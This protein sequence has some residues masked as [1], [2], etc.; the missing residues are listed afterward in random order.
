MNP[1][2]DRLVQGSEKIINHYRWLLKRA[3][4]DRERAIYERRI[5]Q[6]ERLLQQLFQCSPGAIQ[7]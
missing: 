5:A 2:I 1:T 4:T 7:T 6:E 3:K